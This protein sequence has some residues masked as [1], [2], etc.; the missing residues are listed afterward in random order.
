[1]ARPGSW[2]HRLRYAPR[3]RIVHWVVRRRGLFLLVLFVVA[4]GILGLGFAAIYAHM[5]KPFTQ[6]TEAGTEERISDS[7]HFSFVT[8]AT[9]GYGDLTPV[10][11]ARVLASVQAL[12]GIVLNAVA[13]GILLLKITNRIPHWQ[14]A[15]V[16]TYD[17]RLHQMVAWVW[18]R[19]GRTFYGASARIVVGRIVP[20]GGSARVRRYKIEMQAGPSSLMPAGRTF[21]F[22]AM[23][24]PPEV[25]RQDRGNGTCTVLGPLT[26]LAGDYIQLVMS[27]TADDSGATLWA[28]HTYR[29]DEIKCGRRMNVLPVGVADPHW[30]E[31]DYDQFGQVASTSEGECRTCPLHDECSLDVAMSLHAAQRANDTA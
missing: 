17:P 6:K 15:P 24:A 29:S 11:N 26:L 27:A 21:L 7:L 30:S 19:D 16:L 28:H 13:L 14:F 2:Q 12:C 9:V 22:R 1:M 18:N 25:Q 3:G 5:E 23:R 4:Y 31:C 20:Q 10:G 8:Q